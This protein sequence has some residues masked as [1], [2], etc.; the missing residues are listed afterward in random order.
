MRR[1]RTLAVLLLL[2]L[3]L[4]AGLAFDVYRQLHAPLR[5][6]STQTFE[7]A[8]GEP[9]TAVL[10]DLQR[11]EWL[12]SS[13][14]AFYLRAYV[15]W[16]ELGGRIRSGEYAL[17]PNRSLLDILGLFMSGQ[18]IPHELRIV[19]GWTFAQALQ[20]IRADPAIKQ[21]MPQASPEEL[22]TA[23]GQ[24]GV[25]PEGRFFPDTYRFSK[26]TT[27]LALLRQAFTAMQAAIDAEWPQRAPDLPYANADEALAMASVVEK[28][29]GAADERPTIAGVFVRRLRLGMRLQ[30]D[31]TIIY[32]LGPRFD[33]NL[34]K[35]DLLTDGP[36]NSYLRTGLPPTPIC[37]P[38]RAALHAALHPADGKTL[39]FVSKGDGTHVFSETL[40]EH[41]AAV[42]Q[43]QLKKK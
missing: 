27:E 15:R 24:P 7:I 10:A 21:T 25:H 38:S 18:T 26:N 22:M 3:V 36:Y 43:Y 42:R 12:P 20:V 33:G 19:E 23:I 28:E 17:L 5:L 9:L 4:A 34:R 2:A 35:I 39:F 40:A 8:A 13:R 32:G 14:A 37:L 1:L 16:N 6:T 41:E 31:P 29:T 11:R 30:T